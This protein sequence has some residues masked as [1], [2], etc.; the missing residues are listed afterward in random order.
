[1]H[2]NINSSSAFQTQ[3]PSVRMGEDSGHAHRPVFISRLYLINHL[4]VWPIIIYALGN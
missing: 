4:I 2:T 1:M 3:D